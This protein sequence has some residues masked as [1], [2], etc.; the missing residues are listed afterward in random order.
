MYFAPDDLPPKLDWVERDFPFPLAVTY[1]RVWE[2]IAADQPIPATLQLKDAFEALLKFVAAASVADCLAADPGQERASKLVERLF[3]PL[4]DGDWY[5]LL[6][7]SLK[8][9]RD[10]TAH[11][12]RRTWPQLVDLLFK[13]NGDPTDTR[14]TLIGTD[15]KMGFVKW[16]NSELGHGAFR[17]DRQ[18][19][20]A[21]VVEWLPKLNACL[22]ALRP[23]LAGR[24]LR[25]TAPD[26]QPHEWTGDGGL[27][28]VAPH[29]H[30]P[31]GEPI[32]LTLDSPD[33][34]SLAFGPLLTMQTCGQPTCRQPAAF[35]F[36]GNEFRDKKHKTY[37][38]EYFLGH[39]QAVK[40]WPAVRDLARH[41][42]DKFEFR[43]DSYDHARL[44]E[45]V[46]VV[47][48]DAVT[49]YV[50]PD[51]LLDDFWAFRERQTTGY[52]LWEGEQG[53][54]KSYLTH[55]L[56][57]DGGEKGVPVLRY[58]ILP[59]DATRYQT[60]IVELAERQREKLRMT[61]QQVQTLV[62]RHAELPKQFA[63]FVQEVMTA[64]QL[65]G[66]IVAID[67]LDELRDPASPTDAVITDFLPQ[68]AD[69]PKGCVIA[70]TTRP[71]VA[72]R[73]RAKLD[74][75]GIPADAR[76]VIDPLSKKNRAAVAK[77][78]TERRVVG[79]EPLTPETAERLVE[80]AGGVFL[81]AS[82]FAR[83][84]AVNAYAD[85]NDLPAPGRFFADYLNRLR[86]RVGDDLFNRAYMPTLM[87]LTA[88]RTPVS[89]QQLV[90]W[91]VPAY[92]LEFAFHDLR[93]FVHE[94]RHREFHEGMSDD[95]EPRYKIAHE[96]FV[97][98]VETHEAG[99]LKD[100]HLTIAN[101]ALR[102][103]E[104]RWEDLD[105]ADDGD[106]YD[107][108]FVL[109]H[110]AAAG[111]SVR[112][113]D[114]PFLAA[115]GRFGDAQERQGRHLVA[116]ELYAERLAGV[117]RGGGPP[118]ERLV[119]SL[120]DIAVCRFHLR[121]FLAA[122]TDAAEALAVLRR[123]PNRDRWRREVSILNL[124]AASG[125]R[126]GRGAR[127][128]AFG[129]QAAAILREKLTDERLPTDQRVKAA[130]DL[131]NTLSN[132]AV[133]DLAGRD[134]AG[135]TER[136]RE[137][138][139]LADTYQ[140]D[141]DDP[142]FYLVLAAV[143]SNLGE[144][145][146]HQAR[147]VVAAETGGDADE[148]LRESVIRFSHSLATHRN[149]LDPGARATHVALE[150]S[151][152]MKRAKA[153][154]ALVDGIPSDRSGAEL[155]A[156]SPAAATLLRDAVA[157]YD[158]ALNLIRVGVDEQRR[159]EL[160]SELAECLCGR[161]HA[162]TEL[163]RTAEA[164]ECAEEA[165]AA[166]RRLAEDRDESGP[167][168]GLGGAHILLGKARAQAGSFAEAADAL[169]YG[170]VE[171]EAMVA[172]GHRGQLVELLWASDYRVQLALNHEEW[173]VIASVV[174]RVWRVIRTLTRSLSLSAEERALFDDLLGHVDL[175]ADAIEAVLSHLP[176]TDAAAIQAVL[177]REPESD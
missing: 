105:P 174:A 70:L 55:G 64:N 91:G 59:G 160:R 44:A 134:H 118:S 98:Y 137:A 169:E 143:L 84:L 11:A 72:P 15:K 73:V 159:L 43:R 33:G 113:T 161:A 82:Y 116:C 34:R 176:A 106:L 164:V 6:F 152:L 125:Q 53:V 14:N 3:K 120:A 56:D 22:T 156:V 69:L 27:P 122:E 136:L 51:Y 103:N 163:G 99:R 41:L 31:W 90:R 68:P 177:T 145:L 95:A 131:I 79:E 102:H 111:V 30:T 170:A 127:P 49:E 4:A 155:G 144:C 85:L 97:R 46:K 50:R 26:G 94:I 42:P 171:S 29:T 81:Y 162:L 5:S 104:T 17:K 157:D 83:A 89:R 24:R 87:L 130:H 45:A 35:F 140:P 166:Y 48:R 96:A 132:Q 78:L 40:D 133:I 23:L 108:R 141:G 93:E 9:V 7:D 109:R 12:G 151:S 47:F 126:L 54:G 75:L 57:E 107:V 18:H 19:Y 173:S 66:L 65:S 149:R 74:A 128:L 110:C 115:L 129:D 32:A 175:N 61:T 25:G 112:A 147:E 80:L 172:A 2:E 158:A 154:A 92:R 150:I 62:N 167:V 153:L 39:T 148:L 20:V 52:Y 63:A 139:R 13:P 76:V 165:V 138:I 37:F 38:L 146:F 58:H 168:L 8:Q 117:R 67:A 16:R 101:V 142:H 77:A 135:A 121:Q 60:F 86:E 88:A 71:T 119:E 21:Q 10:G 1:R 36:E 114:E 100:A 123:L 124:L 28:H